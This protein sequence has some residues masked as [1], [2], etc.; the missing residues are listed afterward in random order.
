VF[1]ILNGARK[2]PN[3]HITQIKVKEPDLPGI[4]KVRLNNQTEASLL[5]LK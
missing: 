5:I 1:V 4:S 3:I 2:I